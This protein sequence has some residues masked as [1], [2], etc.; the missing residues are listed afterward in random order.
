MR[1]S[2]WSSD[3]CSSD[4]RQTKK[5]RPVVRVA[6]E[7]IPVRAALWEA[8][9]DTGFVLGSNRNLWKPMRKLL[10]D[11]GL[12]DAVPHSFPHN[13]AKIGRASW[14]ERVCHSVYISVV[15]GT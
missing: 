11:L 15:A 12:D 7:L 8:Y 4:L 14:R 6:E 2:D 1:I 13:R 5:R 9:R 3:V 10:D